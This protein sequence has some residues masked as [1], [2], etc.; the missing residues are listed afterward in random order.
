MLGNVLTAY[1]HVNNEFPDL[2]DA[3]AAVADNSK[4][5]G[6]YP[7]GRGEVVGTPLY[8]LYRYVLPQRVG[9]FSRFGHK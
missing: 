6:H 9:F 2:I 3:L 7:V 8:G 4:G 1:S 5:F